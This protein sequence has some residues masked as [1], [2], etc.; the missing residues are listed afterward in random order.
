[1]IK[2]SLFYLIAKFLPAIINIITLSFYTNLISPEKYGEYILIL[3]VLISISII[4][5]RWINVSVV[6]FYSTKDYNIE[7]NINLLKIFNVILLSIGLII[8]I[9]LFNINLNIIFGVI[10]IIAEM[11]YLIELEYLKARKQSK[12]FI[13]ISTLKSFLIL[14]LSVLLLLFNN[15]TY[16][17]FL[18]CIFSSLIVLLIIKKSNQNLIVFFTKKTIDYY[19]I[20]EIFKYGFPISITGIIVVGIDFGD[21]FLIEYYLNKES[22]GIYALNYDYAQRIIGVLLVAINMASL[23]HIFQ[24]KT[25]L[26]SNDLKNKMNK[27]QM[28]ILIFGLPVTLG[29]MSISNNLL[30]ILIDDRYVFQSNILFNVIVFSIFISA[31]R[32]Y[33]LNIPLQIEKKTYKQTIISI[34]GLVTNILVNIVLLNKFGLLGAALS[35]LITFCLMALLTYFSERKYKLFYFDKSSIVKITMSSLI[36][37]LMLKNVFIIN[38]SVT[39]IVKII[40]GVIIYSLLI[41]IFNPYK[42]RSELK[43][44][45]K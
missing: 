9:A 7:N 31:F 13:Y 5:N 34:W 15:E 42:I 16:N 22:V 25:N 23:P 36:M 6:R 38:H 1:M 39:L 44:L 18:A 14:I 4:L 40:A 45:L 17:I 3:T 21:R 30:E 24:E 26:N 33:Y 12:K 19:S 8:Y 29:L 37:F 32:S 2:D 11:Y 10:Y 41:L 35:T 43:I 27:V 20:K 28:M